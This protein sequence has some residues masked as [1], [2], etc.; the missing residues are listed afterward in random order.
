MA[1]TWEPGPAFWVH[2]AY[3]YALVLAGTVLV[4]RRALKGPRLGRGHAAVLLVGAF[5]PWTANAIYLSGLSPF[6][7][8]DLTPF[9]F[10]LTSL[11]VA[12]GLFRRAGAATRRGR[13][14]LPR[15]RS[16]TRSTRSR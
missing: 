10:G 1:P 4:A 12:W 3:S 9:G 11:A 2:A 7:N 13:A 6:G 5:A 14:A 16:I 8:L 15:P